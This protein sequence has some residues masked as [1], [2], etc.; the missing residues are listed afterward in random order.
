MSKNRKAGKKRNPN[1]PRS[2]NNP[3]GKRNDPQID[4]A[5]YNRGRR[6]EGRRYTEWMP[7]VADKAREIM[8]IP[9]GRR[10]RRISA[11]LVSLVKSEENLSYWDL[12]KH[13]DKHP[14]DL[15]RCELYRPYSRAQYQLHVSGIKPKVQQ[16]IITWMAGEDAVHGTKIADSSGY[17]IARYIEWQNAKYGKLSVHDFAKLH[18][19]RTLHGKICAAMVTPGKANDSPYLKKMMDMM[20]RGSGDVLGD[21]AYGGI[22]NCNA[23]RDSGRRPVIDPKSDA[24]PKGFNARAEMLRFRNEHP[25]TFHNILRIRNNVESVFSSMKARFGGVV[26]ALKPHTQAVELLSMCICYNMTFA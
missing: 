2:K 21:A 9:K 19:I 15:E 13:F 20:P 23:I 22:K 3:V 17:S 11:I 24:M 5:Q 26:R 25:R 6:D 12:V 4:W 8:D 10:D 16:Q 7:R 1:R 18:V 14:E